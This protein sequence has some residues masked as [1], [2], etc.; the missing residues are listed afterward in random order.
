VAS[1]QDGEPDKLADGSQ[2][3][4]TNVVIMAVDIASTGLHDVLGNPSP[5]DVTVGKN[6]VWVLRDGKIIQ[7]TWSRPTIA[8]PI[9]LRDRHGKV[10]DLSPGR[11]WIEL[12]PRPG[13]PTRG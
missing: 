6:P 10:I 3:S 1:D 11:T 8:S 5:L 2:I 7:G 4:T 9:T 13:V 12:L